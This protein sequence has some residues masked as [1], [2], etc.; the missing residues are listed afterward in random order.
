MG[1]V[2]YSLENIP[3]LAAAVAI[4][5]RLTDDSKDL[6]RKDVLELRVT[7]LKRQVVH[8]RQFDTVSTLR[9]VLPTVF[10]VRTVL[11][12]QAERLLAGRAPLGMDLGLA[13]FVLG[14]Q[15]TDPGAQLEMD[16]VF[17]GVGAFGR[18]RYALR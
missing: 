16:A 8:E 5:Q 7:E 2:G 13:L 1:R 14:T 17:A 12:D 4:T 18:D 6:G 11:D 3:R 10:D 15:G 9:V